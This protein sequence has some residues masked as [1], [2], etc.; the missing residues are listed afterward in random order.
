MEVYTFFMVM[1]PSSLTFAAKLARGKE[2]GRIDEII[3]NELLTHVRVFLHLLSPTFCF[4]H[5]FLYYNF[6]SF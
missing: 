3:L 1:V 5:H 4:Y 6:I 2:K